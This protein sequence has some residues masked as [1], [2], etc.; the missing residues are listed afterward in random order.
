MKPRTRGL[1]KS[2]FRPG[3][4]NTRVPREA[5]SSAFSAASS[6]NVGA[7]NQVSRNTRRRYI[8]MEHTPRHYL[9]S[10]NPVKQLAKQGAQCCA[11][12]YQVKFWFASAVCTP[13]ARLSIASPS[14]K[15]EISDLGFCCWKLTLRS[16]RN[17]ALCDLSYG[18]SRRRRKE[19]R[20]NGLFPLNRSSARLF[21]FLS[22]LKSA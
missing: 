14:W 17:N 16:P 21:L 4:H 7:I 10:V 2:S 3:V 18:Q 1:C 19:T 5:F 20:R 11:S 12:F 22:A 13:S 15:A 8:E 9:W 6:R